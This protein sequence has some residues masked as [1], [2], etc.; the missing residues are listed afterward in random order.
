MDKQN[1]SPPVDLNRDP[2]LFE[3]V[4]EN[5]SMNG[6]PTVISARALGLFFFIITT[7]SHISAE[8]LSSLLKEGESAIATSLKELRSLGYLELVNM[9]SANGTFSKV[10]KVTAKGYM[11]F[12]NSFKSLNT[13]NA[14][15]INLFWKLPENQTPQ[16]SRFIPNENPSDY[17]VLDSQGFDGAGQ[18]RLRLEENQRI[19][20]ETLYAKNK[21]AKDKQDWE[22]KNK[23]KRK[24]QFLQRSLKPDRTTWTH[25]DVSFEFSDRIQSYWNIAPW[26]VTHTR[27]RHT[28]ADLRRRHSSNGEL[29]CLM[30]DRFF[31]TEKVSHFTDANFLMARFFYRF[32]E[33]LSY[34]KSRNYDLSEEEIEVIKNRALRSQFWLDVEVVISKEDLEREAKYRELCQ[35]RKLDFAVG[36]ISKEELAAALEKLGQEF[37]GA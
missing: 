25:T 22:T 30:M 35:Q 19:E 7:N 12:S 1:D 8:N 4:A 9:R 24:A 26:T 34:V 3:T 14:H 13:H 18:S 2:K 27:F 6:D 28:L 36:I 20:E 11:F 10:T 33:L 5:E 21:L 23:K 32:P 16:I 37:D 17:P 31:E 29:E 15:F